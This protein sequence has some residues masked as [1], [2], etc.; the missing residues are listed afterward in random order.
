MR[1]FGV[2]YRWTGSARRFTDGILPKL[3]QPRQLRVLLCSNASPT[4]TRLRTEPQRT[5]DQGSQP[6]NH[7]IDGAPT[8]VPSLGLTPR[9]VPRQFSYPSTPRALQGGSSLRG[10][11]R[12]PPFCPFGSTR[13]GPCR[14]QPMQSEHSAQQLP[15]G[16]D[17]RR[18]ALSLPGYSIHIRHIRI[19]RLRMTGSKLVELP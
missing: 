13:S 3:G 7:P 4:C 17:R 14:V 12:P 19:G 10:S 2:P 15:D 5:S 8:A 18:Y 1:C 16:T 9:P 6:K 11:A